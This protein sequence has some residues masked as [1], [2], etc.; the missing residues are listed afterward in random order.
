MSV[1]VYAGTS[2]R[3]N[4]PT[5]RPWT[6]Y[7]RFRI[8]VSLPVPERLF[9]IDLNQ[10]R[11]SHGIDQN[12][13]RLRVI[14]TPQGLRASK[15]QPG[16]C[17]KDVISIFHYLI[18]IIFSKLPPRHNWTYR[19]TRRSR[20]KLIDFFTEIIISRVSMSTVLVSNANVAIEH[21][22]DSDARSKSRRFHP[23]AVAIVSTVSLFDVNVFLIHIFVAPDELNTSNCQR[24]RRRWRTTARGRTRKHSEALGRLIIARHAQRLAIHSNFQ[25]LRLEPMHNFVNIL[26]H[27]FA[28]VVS[29]FNSLIRIETM[30]ELCFSSRP[31]SDLRHPIHRRERN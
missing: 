12:C 13:L 20:N 17:R 2:S 24:F 31:T 26:K 25:E 7:C 29:S 9:E 27:S 10:G 5:G 15:S 30:S 6:L 11:F 16:N 23:L 18:G 28:H 3:S 22:R 1:S 19:S 21:Y 4:T 8:E 14:G